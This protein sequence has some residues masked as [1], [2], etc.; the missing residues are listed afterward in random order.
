MPRRRTPNLNGP[1]V[2]DLLA[3]DPDPVSVDKPAPVNTPTPVPAE[4]RTP[5]QQRI[6]ELENQLALERGAKDPEIELEVP[7]NPGADGNIVMHVLRDGFTVLGQVWYR[8]QELEFEVGS[9]A[10]Q[11]TFDRLGN[12]W[13]SL[14]DDEAAQIDRWGEICIRRGPWPGKSYLDLAGVRYEPLRTAE[15][16]PVKP[17]TED[18]L[19][20][21][22]RAEEKRR[23]AAPRLPFR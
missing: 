11:D 13:L 7:T 16:L 3:I 2:I 19:Q 9:P 1:E 4:Q 22:A 5:E 20:A 17:P 6:R 18:E 10:Y 21:A 14:L 23:R 12:T 15:G 8:G